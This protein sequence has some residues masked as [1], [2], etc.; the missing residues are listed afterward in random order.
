MS[1]SFL[2][3]FEMNDVRDGGLWTATSG[4]GAYQSTF[5]A[6]T[7]TGSGALF[8][9][10]GHTGYFV[11]QASNT[12]TATT[13]STRFYIYA[14]TTHQEASALKLYQLWGAS[15]LQLSLR[16][17]SSN[18]LSLWNEVA[19]TQIGSSS[20][21]LTADTWNMIQVV[22]SGGSTTC[23]AALNGTEFAT[24]TGPSTA[25]GFKKIWLGFSEVCAVADYGYF[26]DDVRV[27]YAITSYVGPG[28]VVQLVP[29]AAGS[30]AMGL[31]IGT[32]TGNDWDQ[33]NDNPPENSGT[34][35][36]G[37]NLDA[38]NDILDLNV[39]AASGT[40]KVPAG[41]TINCV[42]IN[43]RHTGGSSAASQAIKRRC[44]HSGTTTA[45]VLANQTIVGN[46]PPVAADWITNTVYGTV[47]RNPHTLFVANCPSTGT[48]WTI[49]QLDAMEIGIQA[50]D[51]S[52]DVF[53]DA[54]WALVEYIPPSGGVKDLIQMGIIPFSR[55]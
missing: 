39:E 36:S 2:S 31:R 21:A 23:K 34:G 38:N 1:Q 14:Y 3:G 27:D 45:D 5:M 41:S 9:N 11:W 10:V 13:I 48:A 40:G 44:T 33:V 35:W 28:S 42:S 8:I 20:S 18:V 30:N 6:R 53:I 54:L 22:Y 46:T 25:T 16:I 12:S 49:A 4:I 55:A 50:T 24:G 7:G 17:D 51:A 29:N 37:Y 47:F 19:G 32:D 43:V 15:A 26:V 52:P